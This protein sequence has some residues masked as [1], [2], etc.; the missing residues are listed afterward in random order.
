MI[1]SPFSW[2]IFSKKEEG[3]ERERE[4]RRCARWSAGRQKVIVRP[5]DGRHARTRKLEDSPWPVGS[6]LACT[7]TTG[8]ARESGQNAR[9]RS[10]NVD[11]LD[12][13]GRD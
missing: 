7:L 4:Q 2:Q 12:L 3:R 1:I 9:N 11:I 13:L 10:R 6:A 8:E 5:R